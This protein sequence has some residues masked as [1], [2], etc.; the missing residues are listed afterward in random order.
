MTSTNRKSAPAKESSEVKLTKAEEAALHASL[1][2]AKDEI[3]NER[4]RDEELFAKHKELWEDRYECKVT[5]VSRKGEK[6][7]GVTVGHPDNPHKPY[8]VS[9][10][11]GEW[12][13]EEVGG[14][15][16]FII[17]K[18]ARCFDTESEELI[19]TNIGPDQ[20][21]VMHKMFRVPRFSVE[22]GKKCD[23]SKRVSQRELL[24]KAGIK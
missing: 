2:K 6:S 15:P 4:S 18:F 12:L 9:I 21:G 22:I 23:P 8:R 10:K 17:D 7:H 19:P 1:E 3:I 20:S 5:C 11:L 16:K 14:L 24:A 13:K